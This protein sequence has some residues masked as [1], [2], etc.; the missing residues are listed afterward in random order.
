MVGGP[1]NRLNYNNEYSQPA[2]ADKEL[3]FES[4]NSG[5]ALPNDD[6]VQPDPST[7]DAQT[8]Y[9]GSEVSDRECGSLTANDRLGT[10]RWVTNKT[11]PSNPAF[12]LY[13][14][15]RRPTLQPL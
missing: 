1:H 15:T 7:Y 12:P 10:S 13:R 4:A 5:R 9:I 3:V 14:P 11:P 2:S 6:G 8:G